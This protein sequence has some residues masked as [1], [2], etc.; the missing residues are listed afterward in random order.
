VTPM[1]DVA[2]PKIYARHRQSAQVDDRNAPPD[3]DVNRIDRF[4]PTFEFM[5][6]HMVKT[7]ALGLALSHHAHSAGVLL[8]P[9]RGSYPRHTASIR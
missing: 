9:N 5:L 3:R 2:P 6:K 7:T 4:R 8:A 1:H